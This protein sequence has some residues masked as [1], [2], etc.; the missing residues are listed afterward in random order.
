V[1]S[2][3]GESIDAHAGGG[4]S[5]SSVEGSVMGLERRGWA[6]SRQAMV[7]PAK[8][9]E[10]LGFFMRRLETVR[11]QENGWQEPYELRGSRTELRG[12][13]GEIPPVY[14]TLYPSGWKKCHRL[15]SGSYAESR[16][17]GFSGYVEPWHHQMEGR[18]TECEWC[19]EA[20]L[21]ENLCEKNFLKS[22]KIN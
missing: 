13:G 1:R 22:A 6:S 19:L 2:T 18:S 3:K 5:S 10:E 12:T 4:S 7:N 11:F 17:R 15:P 8:A 20:Q 16:S 9:G 21:C 14:P